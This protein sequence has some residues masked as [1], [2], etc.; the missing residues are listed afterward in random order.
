MPRR[1]LD[2]EAHHLV[3]IA[4]ELLLDPSHERAEGDEPVERIPD[5]CELEEAVELLLRQVRAQLR[6]ADVAVL[7]RRQ[8]GDGHALLNEQADLLDIVRTEVGT[9]RLAHGVRAR[10][11]NCG[12][13]EIAGEGDDH[14]PVKFGV[15]FSRKAATP[16]R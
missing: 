13:D 6:K 12:E 3:R 9:Q 7:E 15:R 16:S 4:L 2:E 8:L 10:L 14:R 11:G 1:V 5:E